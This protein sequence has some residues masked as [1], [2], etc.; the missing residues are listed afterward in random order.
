MRFRVRKADGVTHALWATEAEA[1][2][3]IRAGLASTYGSRRK[4]HGLVLRCNEAEAGTLLYGAGNSA[5]RRGVHREHVAQKFYI[6]QH[7]RS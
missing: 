3:L 6:W 7:T 1:S 2:Q 5:S 4:V